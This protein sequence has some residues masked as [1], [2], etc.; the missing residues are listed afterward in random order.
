MCH[1][2]L[3]ADVRGPLSANIYPSNALAPHFLTS[4]MSCHIQMHQKWSKWEREARD[5]YFKRLPNYLKTMGATPVSHF[6][7]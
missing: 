1:L 3:S 7:W 2:R 5:S 6:L 4:M